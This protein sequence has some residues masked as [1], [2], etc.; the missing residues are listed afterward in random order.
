MT[1]IMKGSISLRLTA[2]HISKFFCSSL[3][4]TDKPPYSP[5]RVDWSC[6]LRFY[7]LPP[8]ALSAG[9]LRSKD[10]FHCKN[11]TALGEMGKLMAENHK[12]TQITNLQEDVW[13]RVAQECSNQCLHLASFFV[14]HHLLACC[15]FLRLK[16]AQ[17]FL[18]NLLW[19]VLS[20]NFE[21]QSLLFEPG[22]L[23]TAD[24]YF[25]KTRVLKMERHALGIW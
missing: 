20:T 1:C 25:S 3:L 4:P 8:L 22:I 10:D 19:I 12:S 23:A 24:T 14:K 21:L 16:W 17:H 2:W 9:I 15:V 5:F 7:S 11:V 18:H 13:Y 6:E